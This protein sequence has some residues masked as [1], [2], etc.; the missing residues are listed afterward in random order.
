MAQKLQAMQQGMQQLRK[1]DQSC[2]RCL[3]AGQAYTETEAS[4]H[5]QQGWRLAKQCSSW[6]NEVQVSTLPTFLRKERAVLRLSV[7]DRSVFRQ[8]LQAPTAFICNL[9]QQSLSICLD[10]ILNNQSSCMEHFTDNPC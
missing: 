1:V 3:D 2:Q 5:M 9:G 8:Q 7:G 10:S 6:A 4:Q